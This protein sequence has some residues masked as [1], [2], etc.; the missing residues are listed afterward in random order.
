MGSV[1]QLLPRYLLFSIAIKHL[2]T[3]KIPNTRFSSITLG[4][5]EIIIFYT[6]IVNN[7]LWHIFSVLKSLNTSMYG[8]QVTIL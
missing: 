5:N 2:P 4:Y 7:Y 3:P 6:E 1:N 8:H